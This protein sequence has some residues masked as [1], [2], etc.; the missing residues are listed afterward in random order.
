MTERV[1]MAHFEDFP[2]GGRR[3]N[4]RA[5]QS[6]LGS[7]LVV[8]QESAP[9]PHHLNRPR[10]A[11]DIADMH[12]DTFT[13]MH[14]T[15]PAPCNTSDDSHYQTTYQAL[16]SSKGTSTHGRKSGKKTFQPTGG[17]AQPR[18]PMGVASFVGG[19]TLE[20]RRDTGMQAGTTK[21]SPHVPG[22]LYIR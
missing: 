6:S 8:T 13:T 7:G 18:L 3:T 19:G 21:N 10:I 17:A 4:C 15:Y 20:D 11:H 16:A 22:V 5:N 14:D 12:P 2:P 9:L 1:S